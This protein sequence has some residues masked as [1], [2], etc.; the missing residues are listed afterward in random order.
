M[1][2]DG[3]QRE[4]DDKG[5]IGVRTDF[6]PD[7]PIEDEAVPKLADDSPGYTMEDYERDLKLSAPKP[8]APTERELPVEMHRRLRRIE[9]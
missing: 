2:E 5:A 7:E 3:E 6:N 1:A 9:Q 4:V 8:P